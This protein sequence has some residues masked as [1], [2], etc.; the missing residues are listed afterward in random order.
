MLSYIVEGSF[1]YVLVWRLSMH[2]QIK[3]MCVFV[4]LFVNVCVCTCTSVRAPE[5]VRAGGR[6][7]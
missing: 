2:T 4:Y 1:G 5:K 7:R 6:D 3:M